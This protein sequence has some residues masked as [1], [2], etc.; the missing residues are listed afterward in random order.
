[1][2]GIFPIL[3]PTLLLGAC[4]SHGDLVDKSEDYQGP[5]T[6]AVAPVAGR[7]PERRSS[8]DSLRDDIQ[9]SIQRQLDASGI[10]AGV[11][12]LDRADEGNEAEII[13]EPALVTSG[14]YSGDDVGLKV[15]VME[16]T[17]RRV[18]LDARYGGDDPT[19]SLRVAIKQLENDLE[20]HYD[21]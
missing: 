18:V 2:R 15:R 3:L 19:N 9:R 20:D 6:A 17:R 14:S 1:M 5:R 4:S 16:K 8:G 7:R 13:I 10:F 11:V 21:K 12:A